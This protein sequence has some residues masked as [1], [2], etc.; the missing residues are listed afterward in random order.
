MGRPGNSGTAPGNAI[1]AARE[2]T[3]SVTGIF[4]NQFEG[5]RLVFDV[6]GDGSPSS[7]GG[8]IPTATQRD[9]SQQAGI[10]INGLAILSD[11]P[12]VV[13]FY[14]NSV[15]TSDGFF[16]LANDFTDFSDAVTNK[17]QREVI[18]EPQVKVPEPT[19]LLGL[20][21]FGGLTL[22]IRRKN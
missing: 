16:V 15:I 9:L 1:L 3:A 21:A 2:G 5:N 10:T 22:A 13:S 20:L 12:S 18:N 14:Q 4:E 6:S 19:S 7:L 8:G 17:I 11:D